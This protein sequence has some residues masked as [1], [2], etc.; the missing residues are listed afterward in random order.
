MSFKLSLAASRE[1]ILQECGK[2]TLPKSFSHRYQINPQEKVYCV[3]DIN[4]TRMYTIEWGMIPHWTKRL[5]NRGNLT[6]M[7]IEDIASKPSSRIPFRSKRGVVI[8]DGVYY[9][10]KK[11]LEYTPYRI[12]RKDGRLMR[13]ACL[14]DEWQKEG[15]YLA[16]TALIT[17]KVSGFICETFPIE[18]SQEETIQWMEEENLLNAE[19]ML[20]KKFHSE[21]YNV[22]KVT[23]RLLDAD[24]NGQDLYAP[25]PE[26]LNLFSFIK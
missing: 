6:E 8:T 5:N 17:N 3:L 24:Y 7:H 11:G 26:E 21:I 1:K 20:Q 23:N 22:Y 10:K 9:L 2:L 12:E 16:T 18:F 13:L 14:W 15:N 25:I 4:P 19:L